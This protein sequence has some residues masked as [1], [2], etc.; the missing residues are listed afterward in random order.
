[1]K[2]ILD[3][4][5]REEIIQRIQTLNEN[6]QRGW[7]KMTISQMIR[8]CRQ[9]DEMALGKRKYRQSLIGRIFGK[10]A[11]KNFLKD[12]PVKRN[13]PTVNDFKM[14]GETNVAEEKEKWI[15]S[16]R[17]YQNFSSDGFMHPFFGK[18]NKQQTGEMVYKHADHHLKQFG[19]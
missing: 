6:S 8:H 18:L 14:T 9:W 13:L 1:M 3:H 7:G 11:L 4:Q 16:M 10:I 19:S 12:E 17:G 15:Q 5:T 2:S